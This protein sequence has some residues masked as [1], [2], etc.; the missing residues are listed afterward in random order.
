MTDADGLS[1]VLIEVWRQALVDKSDSVKI[2]GHRYRVTVLKAKHLRQ[3]QFEFEGQSVIGIEQNS[4]TSS[5]WA[6][7]ARSGVKVMQFIVEGRYAANVAG[8]KV[9]MYGKRVSEQRE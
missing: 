4:N 3:V 7:M 5:R 8:G 1:A 9:T 2:G 6:E